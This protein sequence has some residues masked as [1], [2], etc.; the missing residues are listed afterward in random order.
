[1]W[2]WKFDSWHLRFSAR[3]F[4][5]R[6]WNLIWDLPI[7]CMLYCKTCRFSSACFFN[8][9][10]CCWSCGVLLFN[11]VHPRIGWISHLLVCVE[12]NDKRRCM[13]FIFLVWYWGMYILHVLC[14]VFNSLHIL[15]LLLCE[16]MKCIVIY[17]SWSEILVLGYHYKAVV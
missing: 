13:Y 8:C 11:L 5:F 14:W 4:G 7:T 2:D 1:M 16:S 10:H 9:Y 15:V 12:S 17:L 6:I 3:R